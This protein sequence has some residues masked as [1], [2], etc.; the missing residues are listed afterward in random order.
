MVGELLRRDAGQV[1]LAHLLAADHQP[2]VGG[3]LLR[4][5]Q[6]VR[7]QHGR[8]DD[9][10]E[11]EDVLAD[12]VD[13]GREGLLELGRVG[14][15][16][17]GGGVVEQR[18]DPDV[19]DV[20]RVPGDLHAPV[21]GRARDRQVLQALLDEAD[22]L[23][24]G[25]LGLDEAGVGG[26]ELQQSR[27]VGGEL[28]EVVLLLQHLHGLLVD[29][30]ELLPGVL[31]LAVDQVGGGLVL[32]AADAVRALVTALVD[33]AL[34]VQILH[35][36]LDPGRVPVLGGA[37]EVVVGDFQ[38][39]PEGLPRL[40]DQL[41]GPLLRT[42]PVGLR[43]AHDL[44]TVLVRAC[45]VPHLLAALAVPAGEHVPS[46]GRVGVAEVGTIIHVVDRRRDVVAATC[47]RPGAV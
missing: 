18:V 16:A 12:Q 1:G 33:L 36:L 25:R 4:Q 26:V 7:H 14:P 22:D 35:E 5:R 31:A 47:I 46:N 24:A 37:D 34:V 10:V 2:A 38:V 27:G 23:V 3:D 20:L 29:G 45:E 19:D 44:L 13:V 8:P 15:V 30:A 11:P 6:P 43:G 42:D 40:L 28:E 9:R 21:E 39:F 41:V 32:L 17:D